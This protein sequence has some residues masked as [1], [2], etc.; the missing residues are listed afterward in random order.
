V[1]DEKPHEFVATLRLFLKK[2]AAPGQIGVAIVRALRTKEFGLDGICTV[3][4]VTYQKPVS[5]S[6]PGPGPQGSR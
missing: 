6:G 3:T 4:D 1:K 2:P 5:E